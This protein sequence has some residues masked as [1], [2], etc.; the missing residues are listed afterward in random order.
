MGNSDDYTTNH[1]TKDKRKFSFIS[2]ERT[3]DTV[4]RDIIRK[5]SAYTMPKE[6]H[7]LTVRI[8]GIV[9]YRN[10]DSYDVNSKV[11]FEDGETVN[12]VGFSK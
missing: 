2:V 9:I 3:N 7:T 4:Y 6:T 5:Q 1:K 8:L 12:R 11:H 10:T